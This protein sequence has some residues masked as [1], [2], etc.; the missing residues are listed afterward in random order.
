MADWSVVDAA[1][2]FAEGRVSALELV[3]DAL[4]EI[5]AVEPV[6]HAFSFVD[7]DGARLAAD[8]LD[9]SRARGEALGPLAGVPFGVKD[10]EDCA[11]MPT[12]RG[13]RWFV[14]EPPV[15]RDDIHVGR[16]RRAG[17]IAVGKTTAPEFGAWAYTASPALGV[18]RNP[19][20]PRCTPGGSSGG[21]AAAVSAGTLP[22]GTAS[23]GGGSIRTPATFCG[24]PGL[25]PT[26]GRIPTFGVTHLAQNAVVGALATTIADTALLLDVMA[27]PDRRDR[28]ALPPTDVRYAVATD[29]LDVAGL[30]V[31]WSVDLGFALVDDEVATIVEAAMRELVAAAD[32][33]LRPVTID[34]DDYIATYSRMESADM[35]VDIPQ[36]RF[37]DRLDELDPL[38]RP[39]WERAATV[40]V[41]KLAAVHRARRE[42]V[43]QVA[44]LFDDIDVLVTPATSIPAFAAEG[45]MPTDVAGQPTH[46]GMGVVLAMLANLAN[47]PAISLPAGRTRS[48]LPVG[49]M[50]TAD[51][52][53]EDVCLRLGRIFEQACP[54]PRHAPRLR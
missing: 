20:N 46:G 17:A 45:P 27:G 34:F 19:W 32:L 18:T 53:R 22:F 48:G 6:L 43:A 42:L 47:L 37:P 12:T 29:Q 33:D 3:D 7:P 10:L 5:A 8:R 35:W 16:L 14:G 49:L 28:T 44:A 26:Y 38:V 9:H 54:W 13:S 11:G 39:G 52:Y 50:V 4:T 51:R 40:T 41:P 21:T 31:G 30:R 24:L 23:D 15:D 36:D 2:A 1:R 25:K